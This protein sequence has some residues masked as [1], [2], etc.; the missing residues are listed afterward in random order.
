MEKEFEK[1]TTSEKQDKQREKS[2]PVSYTH[3][4]SR[5]PAALPIMIAATLMM[6]PVSIIDVMPPLRLPEK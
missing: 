4:L 5:S 6:T 1:K 3:L 2:Q